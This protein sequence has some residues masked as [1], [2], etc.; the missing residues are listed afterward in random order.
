MVN[1][2]TNIHSRLRMLF[3][4]CGA[5]VAAIS[6]LLGPFS[7]NAESADQ[8]HLTGCFIPGQTLTKTAFGDKP[9]TPCSINQKMA[10][11][12]T[13]SSSNGISF[14]P[15]FITMNAAERKQVAIYGPFTV[16]AACD[17]S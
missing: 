14:V 10:T 7:S 9:K 12:N 3:Y 13:S 5:F 15:F 16:S 11:L 6:L 4:H 17:G 1:S 8:S 2:P